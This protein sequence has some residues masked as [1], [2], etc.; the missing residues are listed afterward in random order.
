MG[1]FYDDL[2]ARLPH[3]WGQSVLA[4]L[5]QHFGA[6]AGGQVLNS[7]WPREWAGWGECVESLLGIE[8][9]DEEVF[10]AFAPSITEV[11]LRA[12][13]RIAAQKVDV[14]VRSEE[15]RL[16]ELHELGLRK[17]VG[18]VHG[19]NDCCADSPLQLLIG[20]GFLSASIDE[21]DR[22]AACAANR[23]ALVTHADATLHPRNRDPFSAVDQGL[24]E[25]AFLQHDRHAEPTVLF[26][27]D[28]F[29]EQALHPLPASG[30]TVSVYSRFD[31]AAIP[32]PSLVVCQARNRVDRAEE[33]LVVFPLYNTTGSSCN[34]THYD[35]IFT[36]TRHSAPAA[37]SGGAPDDCATRRISSRSW[38]RS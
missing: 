26:F 20:H 5:E 32:A 10:L 37:A 16:V 11:T 13:I 38:G 18:R 12:F 19:R 7:D 25:T 27:M 30:I 36:S 14:R 34:G 24:C 35:P 29:R 15:E 2:S 9:Q 8:T 3:S 28:W 1:T 33:E 31:S 22:D 23:A 21:D 17:G 4:Q 6:G